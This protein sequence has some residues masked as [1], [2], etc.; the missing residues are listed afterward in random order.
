M[1]QDKQDTARQS[2]ADAEDKR[3]MKEF[4]KTGN[5]SSGRS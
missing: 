4:Q 5:E 1:N 3:V 2:Q